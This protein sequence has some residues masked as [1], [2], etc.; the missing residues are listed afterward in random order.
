M[1]YSVEAR[2]PLLDHRLMEFAASLPPDFKLKGAHTKRVLKEA[3]RGAVPD[4][5]L[6]R[7]KQ[8]FGVPLRHWFRDELRHLPE[9]MLLDPRAIDR[10]WFNRAEVERLIHEH[11]EERYDHSL[12]L[13]ALLQLEM[14]HREILEPAVSVESVSSSVAAAG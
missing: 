9:E 11:R 7:P 10:G 3:F 5:I 6:D 8:G 2:S 1:A 4:E 13:W 14:W 12:R